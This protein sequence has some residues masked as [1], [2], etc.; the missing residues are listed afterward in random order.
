M[1]K[2]DDVHAPCSKQT[3]LSLSHVESLS[4]ASLAETQTFSP[5]CFSPRSDTHEYLCHRVLELYGGE[6][7]GGCDDEGVAGGVDDADQHGQG[8]ERVARAEKLQEPGKGIKSL[9]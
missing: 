7:E 1:R 2:N 3:S 6:G 8:H 5:A 4:K 9:D